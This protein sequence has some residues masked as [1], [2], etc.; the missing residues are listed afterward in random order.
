M[1]LESSG[2]PPVLR[3]HRPLS[4]LRCGGLYGGADGNSE[5]REPGH[6][7][8]FQCGKPVVVHHHLL[9]EGGLLVDY[10][11]DSR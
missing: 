8:I 4:G 3:A 11:L 10:G 9:D 1:I 5:W 2:E 6:W 7:D